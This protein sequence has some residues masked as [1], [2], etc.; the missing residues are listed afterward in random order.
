[1]RAQQIM[2]QTDRYAA[3][4]YKPLEVVLSKAGGVW[5]QDVDGKR[6]LDCLSAYSALSHGHQ[7]PRILAALY[8]QAARLAVT[9]R[10]FHNDR[11]GPWCEKLARFCEMDMVLAMN[12]GAE[13]VETAVK[14]ARKWAYRV[15][16]V[17]QNRAKIITCQNN[18]HGRTTTVISF[19]TDDLSRRYFGPYTP[20][21]ETIPYGDIDALEAAV[22]D[23]T[24]AFLVEPIQ[25]EAGVIVPPEGYLKAAREICDRRNVL[26][27][28]D[29]IQTG[30]GRTGKRFAFQHEGVR[31]DLLI[32]GKA[33][34]GGVLP[35]SAVIAQRDVME[36]FTPGEHGSTF[37][38]NPLACHVSSVALDVLVEEKLT[39]NSH[40]MGERF[41]Q[42]LKAIPNDRIKQVRGKGL[43]L[44]VEWQ[45]GPVTARQYCERLMKAGLLCKDTHETTIR[46]APP[47]IITADQVDW[48]L[49]RI[50]EV[51]A[52]NGAAGASQGP[53]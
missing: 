22:D 29:E 7:H 53:F 39:E 49:E 33:L 3:H 27:V 37:G 21:F 46:F 34:G 10:A 47:L 31:P 32:L 18:F 20:G 38:G 17:A 48:A 6:Y 4:N 45:P 36:L 13:A 28:L 14:L 19:S 15:K 12:T 51:F 41:K 42:G 43:L 50:A 24:A 40:A 26:L 44:A 11:F 16:G 9:S 23:D 30:L 35:I 5:V 52:K 25:G 1:M 8:E 2:E